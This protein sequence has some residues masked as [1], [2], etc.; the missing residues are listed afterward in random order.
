MA[1]QLVGD[2][3]SDVL[4]PE[5]ELVGAFTARRKGARNTVTS[6]APSTNPPD[7]DRPDFGKRFGRRVEKAVR[8]STRP[9]GKR[10]N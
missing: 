5:A 2:F 7:V 3:E 6:A 9:L 4:M 1:S 10:R 8:R